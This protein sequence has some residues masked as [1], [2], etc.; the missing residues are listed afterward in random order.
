MGPFNIVTNTVRGS[1]A[2][3][4]NLFRGCSHGKTTFPITLQGST[5]IVCLD[6]GRHGPYDWSN[7]RVTGRMSTWLPATQARAVAP[8]SKASR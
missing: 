4:A 8:T 3:L 1:L 5:Y 6:C 2:G 7:M